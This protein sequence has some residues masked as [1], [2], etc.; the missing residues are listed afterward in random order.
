[1]IGPNQHASHASATAVLTLALIAVTGGE[2]PPTLPGDGFDAGKRPESEKALKPPADKADDWRRDALARAKVWAPPEVEV[3]RAELGRNPA[4]PGGWA[5]ESELVCK[6]R[7]EKST[8]RTP[9]FECVFENGE[10]LKVKYGDHPE[11]HT[12]VAATRLLSALGF[13]ADSMYVTRTVRCFGCPENPHALIQCI[14]SPFEQLKREC[15]PL[16]GEKSPT[17]ELTV[18]LDHGKYTDFAWVAVER[19]KPGRLIEVKEDEGW[20]FEELDKSAGPAG[21]TRAERDALRI[22]AAFLNNWDNRPANQRLLCL[23]GADEADPRPFCAQPFAYM[24][25]VGGTFGRVGGEKEERKLD[26]AAWG[27]VPVFKDAR[28]CL[29]KV[30]SPRLH[31]ATFGEATVTEAGRQLASRQLGQLSEAQVRDLFDGARFDEYKAGEAQDRDLGNWVRAFQAKVQEIA[32]AG[33]C[34]ES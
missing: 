13:G 24:H 25:D 33:P 27:S 29:V 17:G 20:G 34:P 14:S 21:A 15:A 1:M 32:D 2:L 19:R 28:R 7:P 5:D 22:M 30:D 10:V 8:G 18:K 23:P 6:F 16:Y 31:G 26:V 4:G 12:E 9:K 11:V 3:S